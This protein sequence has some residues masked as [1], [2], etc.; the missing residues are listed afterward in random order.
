VVTR[1]LDGG[2]NVN[3][4]MVALAGVAA[5]LIAGLSLARLR[6]PTA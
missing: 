3:G 2:F 1:T 5:F 4:L 6:T